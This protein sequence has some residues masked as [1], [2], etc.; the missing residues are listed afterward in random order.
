MSYFQNDLTSVT[1]HLRPRK[2]NRVPKWLGRAAQALYYSSLH[3]IHPV[4]ATAIHDAHGPKPFTISNIIGAENDGDLTYLNPG[5]PVKLRL[6][7]L[8]PHITAITHNTLLPNWNG[9][10]IE[11]H[12]QPLRIIANAQPDHWSQQTTFAALLD[13]APDC[14]E[15]H[16][17][18][19]SPTAFKSTAGHHVPLPQPELVFGSLFNRWN[20]F[21]PRR[22]SDAVS[23]S[24]SKTI[25]CTKADVHTETIKFARGNKGVI[26]GFLGHVSFY[27]SEQDSVIRR[28]I[29]ALAAFALYSGIGVH[30]T[31]GM[32]QVK[33]SVA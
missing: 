17:H 15:V 14:R 22:M 33:G 29:Q 25:Q 2:T 27:I 6:T 16:M 4:I 23:D 30:T 18:F 9:T 10:G 19:T 28:H 24:I 11:L 20:F 13:R 3:D 1:L 32:G 12:G 26:S 5:H 8:H 7:T 21:A 31:V